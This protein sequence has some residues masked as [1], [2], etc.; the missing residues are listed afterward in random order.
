MYLKQRLAAGECAIGAGIYSGS[1]EMIEYATEGM[2][3]IWL[4][5]QHTHTDWQTLVYGVRTAYTRRIPTLVRTWTPT[6]SGINIKRCR[7][8]SKKK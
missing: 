6:T 8:Y 7:K 5:A 4:E 3:R 1:I 2:D